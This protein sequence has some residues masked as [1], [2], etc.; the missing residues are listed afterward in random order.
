MGYSKRDYTTKEE[1]EQLVIEK[2]TPKNSNLHKIIEYMQQ[3]NIKEFNAIVTDKSFERLRK[4][5][6][7]PQIFVSREQAIEEIEGYFKLC[8]DYNV[9]PTIASLALYLGFNKD[10][11]YANM[12]NT[13]CS[14]SDVLKNAVA[15]CHSMQELPALDGTLAQPTY[16]FNAKNYFGMQDAQQIQVSAQ[17]NTNNPTNTISAIKEQLLLENDNNDNHN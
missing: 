4:N 12:H 2:G 15:T 10:S 16:I 7:R 3:P 14:F 11:L 8:Y 5:M 9:L 6:G 17:Q 1:R 13:N